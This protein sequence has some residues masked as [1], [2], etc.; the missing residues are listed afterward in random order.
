MSN[1]N[2]CIDLNPRKDSAG[3]TF[4]IGKLKFPGN[5]ILKD[6]AAFLV[7][8]S[9]PGSEELQIASFEKNEIEK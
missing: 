3:R 9:E 2:L 6:G 1:S 4:Y 5:I 8:V 7:F